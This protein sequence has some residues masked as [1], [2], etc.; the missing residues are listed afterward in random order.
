MGCELGPAQADIR[1]NHC[2]AFTF[3]AFALVIIVILL[4][5]VVEIDY[6]GVSVVGAVTIQQRQS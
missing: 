5:P 3:F 1:T 4:L 6:E 2:L